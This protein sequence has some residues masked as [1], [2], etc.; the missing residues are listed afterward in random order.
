MMGTEW[1][2]D[3]IEKITQV[4]LP[5]WSDD[6]PSEDEKN[7]HLKAFKDFLRFKRPFLRWMFQKMQARDKIEAESL[8]KFNKLKQRQDSLLSQKQIIEQQLER[9]R[10]EMG[11]PS[12]KR[13]RCKSPESSKSSDSA[14]AAGDAPQMPRLEQFK[15]L[16]RQAEMMQDQGESDGDDELTNL[17]CTWV[18]LQEG[19]EA[20]EITPEEQDLS[21]DLCIFHQYRVRFHQFL[22]G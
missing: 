4:Q 2:Q 7:Y 5:E 22:H 6:P 15:M 18:S 13:S 8:Q 9:V 11:F 12:S 21:V 17:R 3:T 19:D 14:P 1:S 10:G 20:Q 16:R